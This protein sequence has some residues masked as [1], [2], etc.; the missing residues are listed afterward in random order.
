[1]AKTHSPVAALPEL[2]DFPVAMQ[3]V[4]DGK[5]ISKQEWDDIQIH[6]QLRR[7][8]LQIFLS[9]GKWHNW[10]VSEADMLG[11]DWFVCST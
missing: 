4:I 8:N 3:A 5:S 6:C 1:M 2:L 11:Q 9:D 10:I 7:G